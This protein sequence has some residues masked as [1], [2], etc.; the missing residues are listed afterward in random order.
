MRSISDPIEIVCGKCEHRY[1]YDVWLFVDGRDRP[2]LE[3]QFVAGHLHDFQCPTCE[4]AGVIS[5][6]VVV[7]AGD[8]STHVRLQAGESSERN[9]QFLLHLVERIGSPEHAAELSYLLETANFEVVEA[10][11]APTVVPTPHHKQVEVPRALEDVVAGAS[12]AFY[13]FSLSG[14]LRNLADATVA[15][16]AIIS[17][18]AFGGAYK[19]FRNAA[20]GSLAICYQHQYLAIGDQRRADMAHSTWLLA[21]EESELGTE[22]HRIHANNAGLG[23]ADCFRRSFERDRIDESIRLLSLACDSGCSPGP[24]LGDSL[25]NLSASLFARF[26]VTGKSDDLDGAIARTRMALE[27][28][29]PADKQTAEILANLGVFSLVNFRLT[30]NL[31]M[32]ELALTSQRRALE[33]CSPSIRSVVESNL[34]D[35]LIARYELLREPEDLAESISTLRRANTYST[36]DPREAL[37]VTHNLGIALVYQ[38]ELAD[39]ETCLEEAAS[40]FDQADAAGDASFVSQ[41]RASLGRALAEAYHRTGRPELLDRSIYILRLAAASAPPK[42]PQRSGIFHSLGA[43]LDDRFRRWDRYEDL[44]E[45]L[46]SLRRA[47]EISDAA[48][49]SDSKLLCSLVIVLGRIY[50]VSNDEEH[51]I[52]LLSTAREAV[53][54]SQSQSPADQSAA[55]GALADGLHTAYRRCKD[56]RLLFEALECLNRSAL[57][58]PPNRQFAVDAALASALRDL[59]ELEPSDVSLNQAIQAYRTTVVDGL[60]RHPARVLTQAISW[61][62]W[63]MSRASWEEAV[64]AAQAAIMAADQLE[65][66]QVSLEHQGYW[67]EQSA[68]VHEALAYALARCGDLRGAVTAVEAGRARVI[69][70]HLARTR[71][72]ATPKLASDLRD[73]FANIGIKLDPTNFAFADVIRMISDRQPLVYFITIAQG[74]LALI[75]DSGMDGTASEVRPIW[76]DGYSAETS[77]ALLL[78]DSEGNP[79]W[80]TAYLAWRSATDDNEQIGP[81]MDALSRVLD[82]LWKIL[83]GHVVDDIVARGFASA[84]FLPSPVLSLLPLHAARNSSTGRSVIDYLSVS[85]APCV[86]SLTRRQED[87]H[88]ARSLT[89]LAVADDR[90]FFTVAELPFA[91]IEADL[92]ASYFDKCIRLNT[93]T[94]TEAEVR[95]YFNVSDVLHFACHGQTD[96]EHPLRSGLAVANN[97]ELTLGDILEFPQRSHRLALLAGCETGL[98]SLTALHRHISLTSGFLFAGCQGVIAS[99][100][101]LPDWCSA[102]LLCRILDVWMVSSTPLASAVRE[103]QLWIRDTTWAEKLAYLRSDDRFPVKLRLASALDQM[104]EHPATEHPF[105]WACYSLTG[106]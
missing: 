5:A 22:D 73:G 9:A 85:Y 64:E 25:R 106:S 60:P 11:A 52:A 68:E 50:E 93:S 7:V 58:T 10:V 6:P 14:D 95:A 2:D 71:V 99:L 42:D 23:Q 41:A 103:A 69:Y 83:I 70:R 59:Y 37:Q 40:L 80:L 44:A 13:E 31:E 55:Y 38:Y 97:G 57:T 56:P 30:Q 102:L 104:P 94:S 81:A 36:L 77:N 84:M 17:S 45:A 18:E 32:L 24:G 20:F 67:L 15:W 91:S 66:S 101:L 51:L 1:R 48:G 43:V 63:A 79:G 86:T 19:T 54:A 47:V 90:K 98:V 3:V 62:A 39:D 72:N 105:Y 53:T 88:E 61:G 4:S 92:I 28:F 49:R 96:H 8:G 12:K 74:A 78:E 35:A 89:A 76:F 21:L 33:I 75:V 82:K 87:D 100:W 34:A 26:Q 29:E 65:Q 27:M 46:E 16:K